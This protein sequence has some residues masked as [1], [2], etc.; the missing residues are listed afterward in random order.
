MIDR[1]RLL[2][3]DDIYERHVYYREMGL[4]ETAKIMSPDLSS[5]ILAHL[6][7]QAKERNS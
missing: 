7:M 4:Y 6:K 1:E 2:N 5:L 3:F